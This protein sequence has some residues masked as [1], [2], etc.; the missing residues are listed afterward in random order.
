MKKALIALAVVLLLAGAGGAIYVIKDPVA[1]GEL[2]GFGAPAEE[3]AATAPAQTE[4][5]SEGF[6]RRRA[7]EPEETADRPPTRE[8]LARLE[9]AA[10]AVRFS[11]KGRSVGPETSAQSHMAPLPQLYPFSIARRTYPTAD[12][13]NVEIAIQNASGI[14]WKTAYVTLQSTDFPQGHR[15]EIADWKIDEIV[16]LDYTF[17][18]GETQER[19]RGLRV[20][21]VMGERRESAL[22]ER[23]SQTRRQRLEVADNSSPRSYRRREGDVLAAPGMLAILANT[24]SAVTGLEIRPE[25][26]RSP[27][28]VPLN[29]TISEEHKLSE[30]LMLGLRETSEERKKAVELARE[31]HSAGLQVQEDVAEMCEALAAA[32]FSEA[33]EE[34]GGSG[35]LARL[36]EHLQEFNRLG[37]E[38][39][40]LTAVSRDR[41]V[42]ALA[43]MART[44]SR[45]VVG[46]V[47]TL[48]QQVRRADPA[49]RISR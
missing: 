33:M 43:E 2:L 18:R 46:Q 20:V 45:K 40:T 35:A 41:E 19:L 36:E 22:A 17:P 39:A 8:E 47:E 14:H 34:H 23:V 32:P 42:S 6:D 29:V 49:F 37:V 12:T 11:R 1:A 15:F 44:T 27:G 7:P 48:E 25:G 24:Q 28:A 38:L 31:F 4:E 21:N 13:I 30:D 26:R 5:A 3:T 16:G 9:Q 10:Q